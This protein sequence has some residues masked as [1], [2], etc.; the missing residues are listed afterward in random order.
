[1]NYMKSMKSVNQIIQ[2]NSMKETLARCVFVVHR[3]DESFC[4]YS[5][6][7]GRSAC[8]AGGA[9]EWPYPLF[10]YS[11]SF[12]GKRWGQ[13]SCR[14]AASESAA[15]C[16]ALLFSFRCR[17]QYRILIG[18][19]NDKSVKK[20]RRQIPL[21]AEGYY[22]L[23]GEKEIVVAGYDERGTYYGCKP[24]ASCFLQPCLNQCLGLHLRLNLRLHLLFR[25]HL[26]LHLWALGI[27]V[28]WL[29]LPFPKSPSG[30][31]PQCAIAAY[32]GRLRRHSLE[33]WSP[34]ASAPLLWRKQDEYLYLTAEERP[35]PQLSGLAQALSR[36]ES[37]QIR[38]L[39]KVA[40]ENEVNF[41]WAI[42]PGRTSN[43]TM[44]TAGCS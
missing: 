1:M 23:V 13:C 39:V 34:P 7:H 3:F 43:G 36:K 35:L 26:R 20:Y 30:L 27:T 8:A 29:L 6:A 15:L 42:H 25:L 44:K 10:P 40:T 38:E 31:S 16:G 22:L 12:G 28:S 41:V 4:G 37:A 19:K 5:A 33:S 14:G 11:P 24:S 2:T 9:D 21:H 18:E 32:S 17:R